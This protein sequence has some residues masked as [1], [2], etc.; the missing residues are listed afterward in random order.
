MYDVCTSQLQMKG[1]REINVKRKR[2]KKLVG[3]E[4]EG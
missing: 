2:K 1:D 4:H 3:R